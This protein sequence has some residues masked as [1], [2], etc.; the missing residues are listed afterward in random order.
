MKKTSLAATAAALVLSSIPLL[1]T[2]AQA[3]EASPLT[4]NI[5]VVSDYRYRGISQTRLKPAVQGGADYAASN[6]L[7]V[8]FW[9]TNIK[10]IEDFGGDAKVE[11]DLYGGKKGEITKDLTYDVGVL[12]YQY[13]SNKFN[14]NAN[15]T[16][17]YGALT[18]GPVT[19]KYSHALT[20]TFGNPDSKGSSYLDLT[21]NFDLGDGLTLTPH[22]G[23]QKITGPVSKDATYTDYTLTLSKA[24][25]AVTPSITLV[26]TDANKSFYSS[27]VNGK[28]L[29]KSGVVVGV[30][31]AF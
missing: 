28:V 11:I 5:G 9:A 26:G 21:A 1:P 2:V 17:V 24:F 13:P 20:N 29:S 10:W 8:G 16:E 3:Q 4:F 25:G 31:Y 30:K 12:H 18:M 23:Y 22:I 19:A 27:P 6:G 15:T 14:P 7:Y